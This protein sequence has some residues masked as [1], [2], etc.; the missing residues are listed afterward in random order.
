MEVTNVMS[1]DFVLSNRVEHPHQ[2]VQYDERTT[3]RRRGTDELTISGEEELRERTN[4]VMN[5]KRRNL[6]FSLLFQKLSFELFLL[7]RH[8]MLFPVFI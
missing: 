3:R 6:F 4:S 2:H 1:A 8:K 5:R 7:R